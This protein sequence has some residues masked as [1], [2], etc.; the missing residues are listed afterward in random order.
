MW[1]V[2]PRAD[3]LFKIPKEG[4]NTLRGKSL[5]KESNGKRACSSKVVLDISLNGFHSSGTLKQL[6]NPTAFKCLAEQGIS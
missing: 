5:P 3:R 6:S 2:E 1:W 4:G